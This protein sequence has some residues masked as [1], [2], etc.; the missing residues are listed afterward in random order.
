MEY[1]NLQ[2]SSTK[3][4]KDRIDEILKQEKERESPRA[5]DNSQN[6]GTGWPDLDSI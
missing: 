2:S 4:V 3:A 1:L 6:M 5:T